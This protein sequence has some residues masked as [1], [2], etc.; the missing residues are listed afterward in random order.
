MF[1]LYDTRLHKDIKDEHGRNIVRATRETAQLEADAFNRGFDKPYVFVIPERQK[2]LVYY[3]DMPEHEAQAMVAE[4]EAI[5]ASCLAAMGM[6]GGDEDT[7][8][9]FPAALKPE[10][11]RHYSDPASD[12][13]ERTGRY[14]SL[15]ERTQERRVQRQNQ[16]PSQHFFLD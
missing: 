4:I 10:V 1:K 5:D 14:L 12:Y 2:G 9:G 3:E 15:E 16:V 13:T 8:D 7:S 11:Q 6:V